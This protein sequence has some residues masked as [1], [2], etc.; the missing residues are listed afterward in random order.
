MAEE[1]R[2]ET[3]KKQKKAEQINLFRSGSEW[4]NKVAVYSFM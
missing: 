2:V 4:D 3:R 1:I